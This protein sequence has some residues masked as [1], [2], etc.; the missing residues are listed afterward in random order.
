M[1]QQ[2]IFLQI[3]LLH[4]TAVVILM[5]IFHRYSFLD[6]TACS[7]SLVAEILLTANT[8]ILLTLIYK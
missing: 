7:F 8:Q 4:K 6:H 2:L 1:H 5:C 3:S